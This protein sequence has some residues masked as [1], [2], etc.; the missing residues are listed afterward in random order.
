MLNYPGDNLVLSEG[1][2]SMVERLDGCL[3]YLR[4]NV[5]IPSMPIAHR[6]SHRRTQQDF[7]DAD[8]YLIR[9]QQCMTRSMTLIK[10]YFVNAVRALGGEV[11]KKVNDRVSSPT[12]ST[13]GKTNILTSPIPQFELSET[14][15]MALLYTKFTSF[16]FPLRPLLSEL[17]LRATNNKEELGTL[18]EDCHHAW[19]GVRRHLINPAVEKEI[20][21]M[22]PTKMPLVDLVSSCERVVAA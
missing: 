19:I 20:K 3:Q 18:L 6:L 21:R 8:V 17:E 13:E 4:A 15:V 22:E 10:M 5:S 16:A 7:K 11:Y 1:F 9:Y 2:L 12:R 14:A